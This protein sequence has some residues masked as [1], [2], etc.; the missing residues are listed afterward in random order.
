MPNKKLMGI[1]VALHTPFTK[2]G[3][4]DLSGLRENIRYE[5]DSGVQGLMVNGGT[6]EGSSL[7][8]QEKKQTIEV[9]VSES[10]GKLPVIAATG[11]PS[12]RITL[13]LTKDAKEA[14][15][16]MVL[17]ITPYYSIPNELGLVNHYK[18]I[19]K[20]VDIPIV[21]Y[22]LPQW[23]TMTLTPSLIASLSTEIPGIVGLKESSGNM[24]QFVEIIRLVGSKISV[25]SGCDDLI[26]QSLVSGAAGAM[27]ALAN[28]APK[29]LVEMYTCVQSGDLKKSREIYDKLLPI[30]KAIGDNNNIPATLKA[31]V[32]ILGRPAG[33]AR[34]PIL[35]ATQSERQ[36]IKEALVFA[37][38]L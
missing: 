21:L 16:D 23:T 30:A 1:I 37:E 31:A 12:T 25:L 29:Q 2:E 33:A 24:S 5:I 34:S 36:K 3:E 7:S 35:P 38:L 17:I 27:V 32:E 9:A 8:R 19:A 28:I 10:S 20:N 18:F 26:F 11:Q 13:E 15:A 22:N 4:L 14:G 6:G